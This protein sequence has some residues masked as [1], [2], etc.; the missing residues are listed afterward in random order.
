MK[1]STKQRP[2]GTRIP[3]TERAARAKSERLGELGLYWGDG[4]GG[5]DGGGE[6]PRMG[7]GRPVQLKEARKREAV[8]EVSQDRSTALLLL[9]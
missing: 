4:V 6:R 8:I 7:D 9:S 3:S 1:E 2:G 5:G